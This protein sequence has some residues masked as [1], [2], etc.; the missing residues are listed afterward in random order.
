[1]IDK[2]FADMDAAI[3]GHIAEV[4]LEIHA[5]LVD[6]P[7]TGTPVDTGWA[8]INWWPR[9]GSAPTENTG[10]SGETSS[11]APGQQQGVADV[12]RYSFS[13]GKSIYISNNVPYIGPLND[14]WS[15][16][17]PAGFVEDAIE[18]TLSKY[19]NVTI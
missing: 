10:P 8:S 14:G 12:L 2:I 7:P 4:A 1:M 19:R 18:R 16:Q 9:V 6:N 15:S 13:G 11:R 5:E 17:S 3:G